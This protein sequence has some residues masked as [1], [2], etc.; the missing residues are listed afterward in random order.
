MLIS[1]RSR[2]QEDSRTNPMGVEDL[3]MTTEDSRWRTQGEVVDGNRS[4]GWKD[5]QAH[6]TAIAM[7]DDDD[8]TDE[9]KPTCVEIFTVKHRQSSIVNYK[10]CN[11][12]R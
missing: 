3:S 8:D 1:Y 6:K 7:L 12:N 10:I 9:R 11:H 2:K 5:C 4:F